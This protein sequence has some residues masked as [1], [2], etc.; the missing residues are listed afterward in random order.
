MLFS[1]IYSEKAKWRRERRGIVG[2]LEAIHMI[3]VRV[4]DGVIGDG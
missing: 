2:T 3:K 4:E 1:L